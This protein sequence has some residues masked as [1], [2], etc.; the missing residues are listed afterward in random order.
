[1]VGIVAGLVPSPPVVKAE[2]KTIGVSGTSLGHDKDGGSMY[3]KAELQAMTASSENRDSS[4][5]MS[6][7]MPSLK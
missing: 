2:R 3:W 5:V 6:S 7:V 4:V 1:M